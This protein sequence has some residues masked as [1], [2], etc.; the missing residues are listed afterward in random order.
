MTT[1]SINNQQQN[2]DE[3]KTQKMSDYDVD[4]AQRQ[5][6]LNWIDIIERKWGKEPRTAEIRKNNKRA[7]DENK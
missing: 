6:L 4:M 3:Q 5:C 7:R 1:D 2:T